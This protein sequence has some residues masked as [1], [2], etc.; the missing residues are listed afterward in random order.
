MSSDSDNALVS[1]GSVLR[2]AP[3]EDLKEF[4]SELPD[5]YV[6]KSDFSLK[7]DAYA[8]GANKVKRDDFIK[9]LTLFVW[10]LEVHP[11]DKRRFFGKRV[12]DKSQDYAPMGEDDIRA[13][14][15]DLWEQIFHC[16]PQN[17]IKSCAENVMNSIREKAHINNG[18]FKIGEHLYYSHDQGVTPYL[19]HGKRSYYKLEGV[20]EVV[21]EPEYQAIIAEEYEEFGKLLERSGDDF[22]T[23]Y[24]ELPM[25]FEFIKLWANE[26]VNGFQDRY[27]DMMVALA[28]PFFKTLPKKAYF[29][30]GPS[31]SGKSAFVNLLHFIFGR[32]NTSTVCL[33]DL[34]NWDVNNILASTLMNAP[35]EEVGGT[36]TKKT[37][38][39][40]KTIATHGSDGEE[41]NLSKKNS[42]TGIV[43]KP[44]FMCYFPSNS[45][46]EFPDKESG[47][48]M[49]RALVIIFSA[50]LSRFDTGGKSFLEDTIKGNPVQFA[51]LMG[52]VFA[53]AQFFSKP[54]HKFFI[55]NTMV[56]ANA[57]L[58]EENNS[59]ELYYEAFYKFFDG[60]SNLNFHYADYKNCCKDFG[61]II[62]SE[63]AFKQRFIALHGEKPKIR[64]IGDEVMR[65]VRTPKY[66]TA[67]ILSPKTY[68]Q[69]YG[70]GEQI[71]DQHMSVVGIMHRIEKARQEKEEEEKAK[72]R[73]QLEF[74]YGKK[75]AHDEF[76]EIFDE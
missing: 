46:P 68:I 19:L 28:T 37:A 4:L 5:A 63:S 18:C 12:D 11:E 9:R 67:Q 38:S 70:N 6:D 56:T 13:A 71:H 25:D 43:M 64:K 17:E 20:C 39:V 42:S 2:Q 54:D 72:K 21:G 75:R 31:R 48:C 41:I 74:A 3:V 30:N 36:I 16:T 40:F 49:R 23:F 53:L 66:S 69:G 26:G 73:E 24:T 76:K 34:D 33:A 51:K 59:L 1:L 7:I 10:D 8:G 57:I 58:A 55:S 29:L 27:W 14:V 32:R 22:G 15:Q 61:W 65:C 50:D 35:D 60:V 45:I 52:Q 62:Q 47:P 44:N